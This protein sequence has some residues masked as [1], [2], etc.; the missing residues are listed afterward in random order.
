MRNPGSQGSGSGFGGD[1]GSSSL[2]VWLQCA[3]G[4]LS[5]DVIW[6]FPASGQAAPT[7]GRSSVFPGSGVGLGLPQLFG[8]PGR[9]PAGVPA[10]A[11]RRPSALGKNCGAVAPAGFFRI[12]E[13]L[14]RSFSGFPVSLEKNFG[15]CENFVCICG[16]MGYN[17]VYQNFRITE[18]AEKG[19]PWQ[20]QAPRPKM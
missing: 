8:L 11:G 20:K 17:K 16:K 6:I 3:A 14:C 7:P 9:H 19:I 15:N 18:K 13:S 5:W 10:G 4:G 12:L 1:T 2:A